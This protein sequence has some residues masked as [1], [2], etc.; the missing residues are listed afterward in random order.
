MSGGMEHSEIPHYGTEDHKNDSSIAT[1]FTTDHE[2]DDPDERQFYFA[3]ICPQCDGKN[4]LKGQPTSFGN[5][6]FDCTGCGYVSLLPAESV[7]EFERSI[8]TDS[9]QQEGDR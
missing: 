7:R 1:R 4:S 6:P 3:F 8:D 2:V 9:D 5:N